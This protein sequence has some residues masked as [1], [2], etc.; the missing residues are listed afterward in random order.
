MLTCRCRTSI[1]SH[2]HLEV[3]MQGPV[4]YPNEEVKDPYTLLI[5]L[6]QHKFS[7]AVIN[8]GNWHWYVI[9]R[10][11]AVMQRGETFVIDKC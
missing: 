10:W 6:M 5:N 3:E 7:Q 9:E 8:L 11:K 1:V 2:C 4:E